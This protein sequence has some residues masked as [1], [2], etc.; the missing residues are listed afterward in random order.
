MPASRSWSW[1][2]PHFEETLRKVTFEF[3]GP[4]I[5]HEVPCRSNDKENV[6]PWERQC[7][8]HGDGCNCQWSWVH[9]LLWGQRPTRANFLDGSFTHCGGLAMAG[10]VWLFYQKFQQHS[11]KSKCKQSRTP[12]GDMP[13]MSRRQN[14][15]PLRTDPNKVPYLASDNAL[16]CPIFGWTSLDQVASRPRP[17]Y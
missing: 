10:Q 5:Y 8:P 13:P 16:R 4:F 7:F 1:T 2:W 15:L 14:W 11:K 3:Q 6:H 17:G 9:E 12:K